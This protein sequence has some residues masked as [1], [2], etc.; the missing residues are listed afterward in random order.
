ML[1]SHRSTWLHALG[2]AQPGALAISA[3]DSI[4]P[5]AP[6]YH[7][8]GWALP[9]IAPMAG[10]KLVL[11]GDELTPEVIHKTINDE[12]ITFA[13]AVP[14]VWTMLFRYLEDNDLRVDPLQR[15]VIAGSAVPQSMIDTFQNRYGVTVLQL[16]GMTEMSPLGTV[17]TPVT[18]LDK[19][20][21]EKRQRYCA[22]RAGCS[23]AW[24]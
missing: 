2:A 16:W 10:A 20:P 18:A 22:S 5:V 9:Y 8:N 21:D 23:L 17:S 14:T 6:I 12:N 4:L 11:L 24:T 15:T 7:A 3:Q 19:L 13:G 1:Y